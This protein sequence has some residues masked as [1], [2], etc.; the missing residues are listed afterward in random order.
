MTQ[1]HQALKTAVVACLVLIAGC[2]NRTNLEIVAARK[3]ACERLGGKPN[4]GSDFFG[5]GAWMTCD[6]P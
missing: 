3:E 4:V 2:D 6:I 1:P 5:M